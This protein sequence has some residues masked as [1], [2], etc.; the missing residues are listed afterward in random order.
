M[1]VCAEKKFAAPGG[2]RTH[3]LSI[4][5]RVLSRLFVVAENSVMVIILF[6]REKNYSTIGTIYRRRKGEPD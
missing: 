3:D 5:R 4:T 1:L 6:T 2:H